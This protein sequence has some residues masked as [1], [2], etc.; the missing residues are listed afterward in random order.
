MPGWD[1]QIALFWTTADDARPDETLDT[2]RELV[3]QRP[4]DDPDALFE[5][6]SVHDYLG[7]ETEAIPLSAHAAYRLSG[8]KHRHV[9]PFPDVPRRQ[10]GRWIGFPPMRVG[11][12]VDGY[13]AYY[14]GRSLCGGGTLPWKW[15]SP[16]D[17]AV[18]VLS[19]QLAFAA[20]NQFTAIT[21]TWSNCSISRV[22]Y[23]TARVKARKDKQSAATDQDKYLQA[24]QA[25]GAVDHIE[26]GRYQSTVVRSPLAMQNKNGKPQLVEPSWPVMMKDNGSY[27]S[28]DAVYMVSHLKS[29]EKGSDV[30]V[31]AHLLIDVLTQAVD[32][33][34]VVSN[35]SDLAFPVAYARTC[36]P[37][38]VVNPQN[39]RTAGSLQT[40]P[41]PSNS[42]WNRVA[43]AVD[44]TSSQM[45]NP[46]G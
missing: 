19:G 32:G 34:I 5:W 15:F 22:V 16:R 4:A 36:I 37:V 38:G 11:I 2:M 39:G 14:G 3:A 45:P 29:E 18:S 17:L 46:V 9:L 35:D 21:N 10:T 27:L 40:T 43:R 41:G 24:I 7:M 44:F 30:N 26:Y 20:A 6:A 31:A 1:E 33:A 28:K 12:Y 8:A 13:N 25:A 23:C 42:S